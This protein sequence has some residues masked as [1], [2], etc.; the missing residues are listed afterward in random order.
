MLYIIDIDPKRVNNYA[1]KFSNAQQ[2]SV[3]EQIYEEACKLED[4]LIIDKWFKIDIKPFKSVLLNTIKKWSYMFKQYLMEDV[5]N[6][7]LY[8]F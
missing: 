5:I 2:V 4:L 6:R 3:Y 7:L 8:Q 1:N